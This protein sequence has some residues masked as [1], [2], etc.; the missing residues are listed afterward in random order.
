MSD[1]LDK[2]INYED[3]KKTLLSIVLFL[4]TAMAWAAPVH[5]GTAVITQSDGTQLTVLA[6][7][8]ED[9]CYYTTTDGVLLAHNGKDFCIARVNQFGELEA[10]AQ[11]AH[12]PS[13]RS[14]AER[15]LVSSQDKARFESS[16]TGSHQMRRIMREPVATTST[17]F[18]HTGTPK[19]IVILVDFPDCPF[20]LPDPKASFEQYLNSMSKPQDLGNREDANLCSVAKYFQTV[21][22]GAF[23]PQFDLYGPVTMPKELSFYGGTTKGG[24]GEKMDSLLKHACIGADAEIDF[25]QYDSNNDGNVD[26]VYII[27]AG[28]SESFTQ[29][30]AKCIWPKSGTVTAGK[31]DGKTI[32]RYGVNNEL[33]GFAGA[34]GSAPFQRINGIGLFCHEFSHC[35]G[36][37]DLYPVPT[38][39]KENNQSMETWSVMDYGEY[40][41]NGHYPASYTAWEREA[42]GWTTIETLTESKD[43]EL[44]PLDAGGTAYRIYNDNDDTQK[45]YFIIENIQQG[46]LNAKQK[47]HGLIVYHVNYSPTT[48]SLSSNKVNS[49]IGSPGMAIV[50][51]DGLC[52]SNKYVGKWY[53]GDS[54]T[55]AKYYAQIAGDPFPGT[56]NVTE[57]DDYSGLPNLT[58]FK[59]DKMNK[60][61]YNIAENDGIV[62]LQFVSDTSLDGVA[63]FEDIALEPESFI[64]GA[65]MEGEATTDAWGSAV[66]K[67]LLKSGGFTFTTLYNDAWGSWSGYAVSNQTSTA[68]NS[69]DDQ[70]HNCV[71]SGYAGSQNFVV[72]FPSTY[73]EAVEVNDPAGKEISGFYV[74]NTANNV[75][76]YTEGDGMTPGEFTTGDWCLL[77]ITATRSDDTQATT[78]VYLADYR[79]SNEADH[80]YIDKWQW[81]S[82]AELGQVKSLKFEITSSR[83]NDWGMTTPGYFCM[84]NLDGTPDETSGITRP[85]VVQHDGVTRYYGIDG[86]QQEGI[87]RGL[88]IIRMSDGTYRKVLVK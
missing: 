26:L 37:P 63:H 33:N 51:A 32:K 31:F 1:E 53:E 28:Y 86:R 57:L 66:T 8:D 78:S 47:G 36:L 83:A 41:D 72:A 88:N 35:M 24:G 58:L 55:N 18:P 77:T 84:D 10:T 13:L 81:V 19:A 52:F 4:M 29:N 69:Y 87:S 68:F 14:A 73:G 70:Y 30:P 50:P 34:Y 6:V 25:S 39:L 9:F 74:T 65:G 64:N 48:F 80:Y 38:S 79:S 17:L 44:K 16:M 42:F 76:A 71:G 82:L 40:L 46:S 85:A 15:Q 60:A 56:S 22:R 62:T 7:G 43:L 12:E 11:L 45:E 61:L 54:I 5:P 75:K 67:V 20:T 23:V 49:T 2:N 59:G 3:M 21:S 27:Y